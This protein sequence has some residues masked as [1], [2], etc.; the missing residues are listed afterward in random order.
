[1]PVGLYEDQ[2]VMRF[3]S[4]ADSWKE[5]MKRAEKKVYITAFYWSLLA[6]DTGDGFTWDESATTVS[7]N[8]LSTYNLDLLY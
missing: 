6:N 3:K 7:L 2:K 5:L 8:L 1:M 4:T